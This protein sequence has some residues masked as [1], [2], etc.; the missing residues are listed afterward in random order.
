MNRCE[1]ELRMSFRRERDSAWQISGPA[2]R[3]SE[4]F[5][6][7][8]FRGV[9]IS[10]SSRVYPTEMSG[11]ERETPACK[12][13]DSSS[14]LHTR[15]VSLC[16]AFRVLSFHV[17]STLSPRAFFEHPISQACPKNY[18]PLRII[19]SKSS[20]PGSAGRSLGTPRKF[21]RPPPPQISDSIQLDHTV[22]SAI[23]IRALPRN[24]RMQ[25][26]R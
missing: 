21:D 26:R 6:S 12:E 7:A 14:V 20:R 10:R 11:R 1:T 17:H 8:A 15:R 18:R 3:A 5:C 2:R 24:I 22:L 16:Y 23:Y 13:R 25:C 9:S 4:K 19:P